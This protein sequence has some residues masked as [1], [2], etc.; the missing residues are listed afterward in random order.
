MT[1][2]MLPAWEKPKEVS[3]LIY[4]SVTLKF[5]SLYSELSSRKALE[6]ERSE[7]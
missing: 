1:V 7:G 6:D 3:G 5:S 4:M 2:Q